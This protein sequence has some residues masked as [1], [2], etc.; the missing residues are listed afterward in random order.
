MNWSRADAW[1]RTHAPELRSKFLPPASAADVAAAEETIGVPLPADLAAWWTACGGLA[2]VDYA[3]VIP[4]FCSPFSVGR[5][6]EVREAMMRIRRSETRGCRS[7]SRSRSARPA[8]TCSST[9][10]KGRCAG[11]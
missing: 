6:L 9:C 8:T 3:P 5:S 7:S 1:L 4:E 10:E 2:G 11:A